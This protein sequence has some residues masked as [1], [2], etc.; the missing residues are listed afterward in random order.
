MTLKWTRKNRGS[1]VMVALTLVFVAFTFAFSISLAYSQGFPPC[2]DSLPTNQACD[3]GRD[4]TLEPREDGQCGSYIIN[5]DGVSYPK[6]TPA[7]QGDHC[8]LAQNTRICGNKRM[9]IK[10]RK[11]QPVE[12]YEC[13]N[14]GVH[15]G[16]VRKNIAIVGGDCIIDET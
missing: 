15:I 10:V 13:V 2:S 5:N 6:C 11:H 12:E 3:V 1:Q 4:C 16:Y 14:G 7:E 8:E 9:C